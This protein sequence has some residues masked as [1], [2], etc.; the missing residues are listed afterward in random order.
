[1]IEN[2]SDPVQRSEGIAI[3]FFGIFIRATLDEL[4]SVCQLSSRQCRMQWRNVSRRICAVPPC[5]PL[6][7]LKQAGD[8]PG[9]TLH[10]PH[11]TASDSKLS[12]A[13]ES[14]PSSRRNTSNPLVRRWSHPIHFLGVYICAVLQ[15]HPNRPWLSVC[16][17]RIQ[18]CGAGIIPGPS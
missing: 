8:F 7:N 18:W 16:R 15:K 9:V 17:C 14:A 10:A 6:Q 11:A 3:I 1:M 2:P 4:P 5:A 12:F 13:F